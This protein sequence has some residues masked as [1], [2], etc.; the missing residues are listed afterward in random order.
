MAYR[1]RRRISI[2]GGQA[3][4]LHVLANTSKLYSYSINYG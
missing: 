2:R 4:L 3:S 1:S